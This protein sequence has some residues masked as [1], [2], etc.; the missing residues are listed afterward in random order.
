LYDNLDNLERFYC[1]VCHK[2]IEA[3]MKK[4]QNNCGI[5]IPGLTI[6]PKIIIHSLNTK[7]SI[8]QDI[9]LVSHLWAKENLKSNQAIASNEK[10]E[11]QV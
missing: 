3:A 2:K 9:L 7:V 5:R 11:V 4:F 1:L 10:M 8:Y 6:N